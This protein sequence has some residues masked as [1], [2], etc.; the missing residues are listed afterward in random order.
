MTTTFYSARTTPG[1]GIQPRAGLGLC[2]VS[3]SYTMLAAFLDEDVVNLVKV[4]AGA[5]VLELILDVPPLT[6]QADVTWD[7]GDATVTGRFISGGTAGRSSTGAIV[8]LTVVGSSQYA[9]TVDTFIQFQIKTVPGATA[10]TDG[11]IKLTVIYTMD[12]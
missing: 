12:L 2:A 3:G 5:K 8:R 11:T 10:V 4:P 7:L 6:D 9:Y 1:S